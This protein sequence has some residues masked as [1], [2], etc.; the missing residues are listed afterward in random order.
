MGRGSYG[1]W[2]EMGSFITGMDGFMV[3]GQVLTIAA[4]LSVETIWYSRKR[5]KGDR[6]EEAD[7]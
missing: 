4:V 6:D 5:E 2:H 3:W 7:R 1:L